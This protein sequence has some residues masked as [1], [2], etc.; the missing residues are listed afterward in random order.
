[1]AE[2]TAAI[3]WAIA[4]TGVVGLMYYLPKRDK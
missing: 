1:V 4:L 2:M 3:A